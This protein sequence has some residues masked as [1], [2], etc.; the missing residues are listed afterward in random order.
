[1]IDEKKEKPI[2]RKRVVGRGEDLCRGRGVK[3]EGKWRKQTLERRRN[4]ST[5]TK[6]MWEKEGR[7]RKSIKVIR[8]KLKC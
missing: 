5:T 6:R 2:K 3:S 7:R 8:R 1:M 4:A